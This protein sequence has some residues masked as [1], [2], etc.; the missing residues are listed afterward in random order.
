ME[1]ERPY[2]LDVELARGLIQRLRTRLF[3]W[4]WLGLKTPPELS[5]RLRAA[6]ALFS[7]AA[8]LQHDV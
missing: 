5:E 7:R 6:T 8:T 1:R 2:L 4:E 3:I